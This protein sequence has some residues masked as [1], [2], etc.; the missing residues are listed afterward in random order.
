[1]NIYQGFVII[2]PSGNEHNTIVEVPWEVNCGMTS[3]DTFPYIP[4]KTP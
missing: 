4:V 3:S 2:I 1:M